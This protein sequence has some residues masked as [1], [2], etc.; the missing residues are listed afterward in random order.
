MATK[1][2]CVT[3]LNLAQ[4]NRA[5]LPKWLNISLYLVAEAAIISTD[6]GQVIGTA[7]AINILVPKIPLVGGCAISVTDTLFILLFYKADG[8]LRRLRTFELFVSIFII[9]VFVSF[10]LELSMITAPVGEIFRGFLP[11]REIFVSRG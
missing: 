10:C 2:G 3:G 7:I 11:S 6:I 9:G 4:M 8:T 5:Y 1:L